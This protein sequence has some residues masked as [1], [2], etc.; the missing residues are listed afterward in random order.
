[1]K[2]HLITKSA[3][4]LLA[5]CCM[6]A[7]AQDRDVLY[8]AE[9][10]A[11]TDPISAALGDFDVEGYRALT[12]LEFTQQF[13]DGPWRLIAIRRT[14][15]LDVPTQ[16]AV[17]DRLQDHLDRGGTVMVHLAGLEDM[18]LMQDFLGV[19]D[20]QDVVEP[21]PRIHTA[22]LPLHPTAGFGFIRA[23]DEPFGIEFGAS[24]TPGPGSRPLFVYEGETIASVLNRGG[25]VI[26]NGYEPDGWAGGDAQ[27]VARTQIEWLLGCPA[28]LNG[29]GR[30]DLFDF[31]EFQTLFDAGDPKADWFD[32]DGEL[33]AFDFLAFFN[34]FEAGCP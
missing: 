17:I 34:A 27:P 14:G 1:M 12:F 11:L 13:D 5:T 25:R 10:S 30:L 33:T 2:Q 24:L 31:L 23:L 28:D 3:V 6:R 26:V 15:L 19:A 16:L 9:P 29:D 20:A 18:P 7:S 22:R 21:L 4:I 8:W 32:Y